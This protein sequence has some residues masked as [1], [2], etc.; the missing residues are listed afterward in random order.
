[1]RRIIAFNNVTL[2]GLF[3]G[4]GGDISWAKGHMDAEFNAFVV[5]NAVADGQ[6]LFGRITYE[7]MASYW[8]TPFAVENDP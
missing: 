4:E 7:L 1:M 2:D 8:P 6:L 5:A 3:A